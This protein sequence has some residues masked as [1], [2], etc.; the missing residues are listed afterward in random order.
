MHGQCDARPT[1]TFPAAW[2]HRPLTDTKSYCLMTEAHVCE[3]LVTSKAQALESNPQPSGSQIQRPSH[4]ALPAAQKNT[5]KA[6]IPNENIVI[7]LHT[8]QPSSGWW[9]QLVWAIKLNSL[10]RSFA[11]YRERHK[12]STT[13]RLLSFGVNIWQLLIWLAPGEHVKKSIDNWW[14][15]VL[16]LS[17]LLPCINHEA[18]IITHNLDIVEPMKKKQNFETGTKAKP[19]VGE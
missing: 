11:L 17:H 5:A 9:L 15:K 18:T 19:L 2:H 6:P 1:V 3:Q 13:C 8:K 12:H 4:Y 14:R 10:K 7:S 16:L